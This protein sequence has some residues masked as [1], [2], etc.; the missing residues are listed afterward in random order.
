LFKAPQLCQ[1]LLKSIM[2]ADPCK[3]QYVSDCT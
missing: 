2:Q 3:Q 1:A